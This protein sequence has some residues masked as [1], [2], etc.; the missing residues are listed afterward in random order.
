MGMTADLHCTVSL[1][2]AATALVRLPVV[3]LVVALPAAVPEVAALAIPPPPHSPAAK[4]VEVSVVRPPPPM[5]MPSTAA[6]EVLVGRQVPHFQY[7]FV[8]EILPPHVPSLATVVEV[9]LRL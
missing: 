1:A 2:G 7:F 9:L 3:E 5:T 6:D 8:F 4:E